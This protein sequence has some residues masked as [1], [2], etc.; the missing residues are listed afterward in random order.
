[1]QKIYY[2]NDFPLTLKL[3]E[4]GPDGRRLIEMPSWPWELDIFTAGRAGQRF[5]LTSEQGAH[6]MSDDR[7]EMLVYVD[8]HGLMPGL[9]TAELRLQAPNEGYADGRQQI[10]ARQPLDIMLIDCADDTPYEVTATIGLP[11]DFAK[12]A[13]DV[14]IV[15]ALSESEQLRAQ[16]EALRAQ[17]EEDRAKAEELRATAEASRIKAEEKRAE[18]ELVREGN[19]ATRADNEED[20][21]V[22]ENDRVAAEAARVQAETARAN[23]ETA[24]VNA[25]NLRVSAESQRA[26]NEASRIEAEAKRQSA[27]SARVTAEQGRASAE[28]GRVS[29]EATRVS[30]FAT[31]KAEH[32]QSMDD[33]AKAVEKAQSDMNEA[34]LVFIQAFNDEFIETTEAMTKATAAANAQ[35]E[36]IKGEFATMK[37]EAAEAEDL[38]AQGEAL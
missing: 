34:A 11:A 12:L 36:A 27:E 1:M 32:Q 14:A 38:R 17:S 7:T 19:E 24:R 15:Q 33:T 18:M 9:L 20:R 8:A 16:S 5:R 26:D 29:A 3:S 23:A 2:K 21:V 4:F 35:T 25:E 6:V 31:I 10:V 28:Q 37:A 22:V 30:E 13:K